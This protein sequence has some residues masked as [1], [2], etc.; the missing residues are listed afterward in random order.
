[1]FNGVLIFLDFGCEL[2]GC[3]FN[4]I[5]SK[6]FVENKICFVKWLLECGVNFKEECGKNI[7]ILCEVIK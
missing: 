2:I 7:L 4:V 5:K 3:L 6:I 1:M